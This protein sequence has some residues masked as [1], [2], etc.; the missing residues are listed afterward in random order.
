MSRRKLLAAAAVPGLAARARTRDIRIEKV[1]HS[2]EDFR[3]RRPMM[4]GGRVVDRVTLLNVRVQVRS[5]SGRSARGFG[6]M[7]LGN[8][9]SFPSARL[10]YDATLDAMKALAA[11]IAAVTGDYKES[12]HPVEINLAL[13][14]AYLRAAAEV[15]RERVERPR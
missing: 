8:A 1:S 6:S 2:F 12:G 13:E 10:S 14:P 9:W 15:T 4:F 7:P 11:R 3:Y 5:S